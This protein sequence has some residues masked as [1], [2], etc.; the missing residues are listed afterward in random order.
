MTDTFATAA[1]MAKG[2]MLS[3]LSDI[4]Q[5]V[6]TKMLSNI[7]AESKAMNTKQNAVKV[8]N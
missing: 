5:D 4:L 1:T 7:F 3:I 2:L 8:H 6:L